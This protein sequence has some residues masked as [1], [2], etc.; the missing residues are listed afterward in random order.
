MMVKVKWIFLVLFVSLMF[1]CA[2]GEEQPAPPTETAE[3]PATAAK[4]PAQA[5]AVVLTAAEQES[6]KAQYA[7]EAEAEI[8]GDNAEQ[9]ADDLEREIDA[10]LAS[11]Q[12]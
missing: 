1:G 5:E 4:A 2:S 9:V 10:E 3:T 7:T 12:L 8:T 6:L 11:E